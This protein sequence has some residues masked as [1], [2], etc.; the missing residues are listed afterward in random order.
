MNEK[1]KDLFLKSSELFL[2][3]GIKS[4]TM[5]DVS[6]KLGISK[7]T[8]Y[9]YVSDK[10][11]LVKK[12]IQL[13]ISTNECAMHEVCDA[14]HNAIEELINMSK[15]AGEQMKKMH[16]SILFDLQK[17]HSEAWNLIREFEDDTILELTK[18]NLRK[19]IE[20]GFY[21]AEMNVDVI[22]V[23]YVSVVNSIFNNTAPI[24]EGVSVS[25]YYFEAFNYHIRGIANN[26]GIKLINQYLN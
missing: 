14:S 22:A 21:R 24:Q 17:Y 7:K 26:N 3:N 18:N 6:S 4:L 9:T 23:L 1:E 16:P 19:G 25:E 13:H 10:N 2:Q 15:V 20:Q 5:N 12:C 8:L 11:D